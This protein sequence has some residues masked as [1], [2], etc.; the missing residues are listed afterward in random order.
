M[1]LAGSTTAGT[2]YDQLRITGPSAIIAATANTPLVL[3][4]APGYTPLGNG[5]EHYTLIALD[6]VSPAAANYGGF[7]FTVSGV[8]I[9]DD[10]DFVYVGYTWQ[11]DY[12]GGTDGNDL[13]LTSVPE[14]GSALLLRGGLG[15]V[16]DTRRR[17][18]TQAAAE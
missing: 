18:K 16:V 12:N 7:A 9:P 17:K 15:A 14:P 1:D 11:L 13:V 6:N 3:N 2:D 10:V 4:L 8:P 5:T